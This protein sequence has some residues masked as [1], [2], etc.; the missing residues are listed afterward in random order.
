MGRCY[1]L[2]GK[3][4]ALGQVFCC[5]SANRVAKPPPVDHSQYAKKTGGIFNFD[6]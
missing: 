6:Y 4:S 5:F 2:N 1:V 3:A